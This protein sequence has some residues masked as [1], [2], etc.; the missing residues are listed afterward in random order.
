[1]GG[2]KEGE[3]QQ[4]RGSVST[5]LLEITDCVSGFTRCQTVGTSGCVLVQGTLQG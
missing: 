1:M 3:A 4:V 2:G 5:L